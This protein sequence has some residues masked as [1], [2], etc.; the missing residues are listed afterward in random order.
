VKREYQLTIPIAGHAYVT[1]EAENEEQ[2]LELA[3]DQ[4]TIDNID[5]WEPIEKFIG[6]NVCYCPLPWEVQIE[7]MGEV[8]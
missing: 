4:I 6:G 8:E 1:V 3:M 5:T 2:A 7:D